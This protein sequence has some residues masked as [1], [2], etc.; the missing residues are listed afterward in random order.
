[1]D[2]EVLKEL[3]ITELENRIEFGVC[4]GVGDTQ[5][6]DALNDTTCKDR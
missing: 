3:Q 2:N 1:M 5:C 4:G 6:D